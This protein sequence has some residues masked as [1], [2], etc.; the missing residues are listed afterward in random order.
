MKILLLEDH[1]IVRIGVRQLILQRWPDAEVVEAETLAAALE[2]AR[3][4]GL[5]AAVVDLNLPDAE[6][7]E[8][9]SQ[10]R[11]AAPHL[12]ILVLSLNAETAYATRA[13]QM[14]AAGYLNKDRAA[15]ELVTALERVMAGGRYITDTLA[16]RLADLM[17]GES[18]KAPHEDL[19]AQE[20]R[21]LVQLAEGKRLTEI[22]ELMHLSPKTVTTY[23][24]RIFEKLEVSSNA[25]LIR[26]CIS[27][28][29]IADIK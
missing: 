28:G 22:G 12:R 20:H 26:Y 1:P 5:L 16:E 17:A 13:L 10:L 27:H 2:L 18:S 7:L 4:D 19:S 25:E 11:K 24:T 6:G 8:S 29:L 15:E 14:G 3:R 23:K 21:V 9:V